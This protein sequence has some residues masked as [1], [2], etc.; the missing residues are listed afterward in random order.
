MWPYLWQSFDVSIKIHTSL[1]IVLF[2]FFYNILW[3]S[4]TPVVLFYEE[5]FTRPFLFAATMKHNRH[6]DVLAYSTCSSL[7]NKEGKSE[8]ISSPRSELIELYDTFIEILYHDYFESQSTDPAECY[9][10]IYLRVRKIDPRKWFLSWYFTVSWSPV[11][12]FGT[13]SERAGNLGSSS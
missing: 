13:L 11:A 5:Q 1:P 8:I 7:I 9:P 4:H 2:T 3:F 6:Y 10:D 12:D